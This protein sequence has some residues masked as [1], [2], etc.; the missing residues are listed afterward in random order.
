MTAFMRSSDD[1]V[2]K[3]QN[4][5]GQFTRRV[6]QFLKVVNKWN[7]LVSKYSIFL[8]LAGW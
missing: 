7:V 3:K 2:N 6:R 4:P 5:S 8:F 1:A